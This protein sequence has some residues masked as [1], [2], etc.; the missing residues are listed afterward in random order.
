MIVK[1]YRI[2]LFFLLSFGIVFTSF[3]ADNTENDSIQ[4][5][6]GITVLVTAP[7]NYALRLAG[8]IEEQGGKVVLLPAV[9]TYINPDTKAID[10]IYLHADSIDWVVLPSRKAMDAFFADSNQMQIPADKFKFCA[11]G[12]DINYL[13]DKYHCIAALV[14]T[15]DG[16]D[17]IV[18]ALS[19]EPSIQGQHIVVV[20][21]RVIGVEEPDVIPNL[22]R[23][24]K[25]LHLKVSKAEAYITRMAD[26][27]KY[28]R[29]L[30]MLKNGQIDLIA[31]TSTAEIEA[32][33]KLSSIQLIDKQLVACFGPYTGNNALKLGLHPEY[34]GEN[35]KSFE[36]F[37]L[38]IVGFVTN[39]ELK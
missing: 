18:E 39:R 15:E 25:G 24:L 13:R 8:L 10:S 28:K 29:E 19:K 11:I 16:P 4:P 33:I 37:V 2:L 26:P 38:G 12:N 5:L 6:Q 22:I 1:G 35:Y 31:F 32:L 17:G 36:D 14:P 30:N 27:E 23:N 34:I 20:A 9:E 3:A 7:S 21:P